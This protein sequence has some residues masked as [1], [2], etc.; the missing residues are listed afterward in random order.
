M[1]PKLTLKRGLVFSR[2]TVL[3][4][5]CDGLW[6]CRCSCGRLTKA[7]AYQLRANKKRSC[8]CLHNDL[9]GASRRR[10]GM[11][12][13]PTYRSWSA[14]MSRCYNPRCREYKWYGGRGISVCKR[15][16]TAANFCSDM[17]GRKLHDS[18]ER[19][20]VNG[21][22]EP[23][24]CKWLARHLQAGNLRS[25]IRIH[26]QGKTQCLAWWAKELSL[27]YS[28]LTARLRR[29]WSVTRT[30]RTPVRQFLK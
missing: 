21:N 13:T 12:G 17:P 2:L 29:G 6:L 8:G 24:N 1:A 11:T 28:A 23:A 25:N 18:L 20:D 3:R 5:V 15:W 16:H 22:Y 14:M 19:L 27:P 10:H 4:F 7:T 9:L 26:Y 30:L